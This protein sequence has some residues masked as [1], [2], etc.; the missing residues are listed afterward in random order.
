MS[1]EA[2]VMAEV[3]EHLEQ[4]IA[5]VVFVVVLA[6]EASGKIFFKDLICN[7][8]NSLAA[9][10]CV[11]DVSGGAGGVGREGVGAGVGEGAS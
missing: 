11:A 3:E 2:E 1:K 7:H 6:V 5:A 4:L 10:L 9:I 8:G